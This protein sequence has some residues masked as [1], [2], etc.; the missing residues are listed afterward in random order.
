MSL[1]LQHVNPAGSRVY[2]GTL[3]GGQS[4]HHALA[5]LMHQLNITSGTVD[6]LGGLLEVELTSYD[7]VRQVRRAPLVLSQ[8]LEIVAG[9]GTL[10]WLDD[11]P[12]VHLHLALSYADEAA[13]HGLAM[14]GGHAA[15]ALAFAVEFTL[16]AHAGP[17]VRRAPHLLTGL[18]LWHFPSV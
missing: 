5:G 11:Q 8:P 13:P 6:M 17:P 4:V 18:S 3:T 7:F 2:Q 12:H 1:T 15:R 10:S 9:H 16:W 14:I